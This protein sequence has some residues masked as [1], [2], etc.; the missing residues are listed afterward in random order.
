ME[1][2]IVQAINDHKYRQTNNTPVMSTLLPDFGFLGSTAGCQD[3]LR[4]L[5]VPC[6][7]ID[8]YTSTLIKELRKPPNIPPISTEYTAL[9]YSAGW[10]KMKEQATAG[11]SGIHFSHHKAC[12]QNPFL[13]QFE[14]LM[15][16]I[17]YQT[18]YS[19]HRYKLSVNAMLLKKQNKL[20]AD[21]LR[22][23][24][25][26][27]ADFNHMN[28]KLGRDL[29]A[30]AE[31]FQMIAPEQFG[32]RK[33][34]SCIDQVIVKKLYYDAL[35]ILRINGFLCSNDAKS[36]YDRITHSVVSLAMQRVGMPIEPIVSMLASL[37]DMEHHVK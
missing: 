7:P 33:H 31:K 16:S 9:D 21:Q 2:A 3:I 12:G 5:Y 20:E 26:L 17:P 22:T 23:I 27:E 24:L 28:K 4:G 35:Q 19:P 13:A 37:Q 34:H 11:L 8:H 14:A 10:A 29:M 30:Q 6:F 36:C 15:C 1:Q 25:L 18:G 32:S